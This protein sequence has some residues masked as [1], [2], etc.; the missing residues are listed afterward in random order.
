MR[1][2]AAAIA[3]WT[4]TLVIA[5]LIFVSLV[6]TIFS[7]GGQVFLPL[8]LLLSGILGWTGYRLARHGLRWWRLAVAQSN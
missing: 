4:A 7:L 1:Y 3:A 5:Y 8:A 6:V 2:R